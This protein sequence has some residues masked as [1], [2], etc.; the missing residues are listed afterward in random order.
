MKRRP[1][2]EYQTAEQIEA[3]VKRLE[4]RAESFADG[5]ARQSALRE[6]A[7]FRTYAAMKRWVGAAKPSADER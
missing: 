6:A 5:D 2:V 1:K 7:K 4:Q 3:E